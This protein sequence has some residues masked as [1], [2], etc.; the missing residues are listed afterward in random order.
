MAISLSHYQIALVASDQPGIVTVMSLCT[1]SARKGYRGVDEDVHL[2][3]P[4]RWN[5]EKR[6][7]PLSLWIQVAALNALRVEFGG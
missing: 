2:G 7:G 3:C 4:E 6:G 1:P 5:N